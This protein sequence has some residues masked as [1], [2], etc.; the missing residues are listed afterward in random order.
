MNYRVVAGPHE[1]ARMD[2][3]ELRSA[4]LVEGLFR[5]SELRLVATDMDR[6]VLGG[7]MPGGKL[8]LPSCREFG[9]RYFTERRE[10][11]VVNLGEAGHVWVAGKRYSLDTLDFLYIGAGNESVAFEACANSQPCF[12]FLS[13]PAHQSFPVV[14]ICRSQV[15]CEL[16]GETGTASRRRLSKYIHPGEV[17][18]CQLVMGLTELEHG[19]VW[20]T[21]PAHTHSRRSEV[22]LYSGLGNGI[23]VHLMGRADQTRHLVVRDRE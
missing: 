1:T 12:Y 11:G 18:S 10:L 23:A 8:C 15:S 2:T 3:A 9:T 7:A 14:R 21:M 22:Y 17:S 19:S 6:M 13:C 16:L 20:N 5:P 4:F